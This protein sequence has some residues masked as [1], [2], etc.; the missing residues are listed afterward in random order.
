[1]AGS[2]KNYHPDIAEESRQKTLEGFAYT[3]QVHG[4]VTTLVLGV[5]VHTTLRHRDLNKMSQF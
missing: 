1:M 5:E 4:Q 3:R 2:H